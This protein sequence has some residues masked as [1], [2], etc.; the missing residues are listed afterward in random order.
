MVFFPVKNENQAGRVGASH[1]AGV[2]APAQCQQV[3]I[4]H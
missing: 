2:H 3:I 4:L 1:T